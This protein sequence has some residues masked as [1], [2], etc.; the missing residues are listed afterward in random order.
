ME[1][2]SSTL[3]LY[4]SVIHPLL[5]ITVP[6]LFLLFTAPLLEGMTPLPA[7]GRWMYLL[8]LLVGVSETALGNILKEERASWGARLRELII[9]LAV[10]FLIFSLVRKPPQGPFYF[11]FV[12]NLV[13]GYRLTLIAGMWL[14]TFAI[15]NNYRSWEQ[16]VY[17]RGDKEG[18]RLQQCL[19]ESIV[20]ITDIKTR[21]WNVKKIC[22]LLLFLSLI[23]LLFAYGTGNPPSP[24]H[25]GVLVL[26]LL[27]VYVHIAVVNQALEEF[28]LTIDGLRI[29]YLQKLRQLVF[30]AVMLGVVAF[31]S[32][33][34]AGNRALLP[35]SLIERFLEFLSSLFSE[36][37]V[38]I[39]LPRSMPA[40]QQYDRIVD[41]YNQFDINNVEMF[42]FLENLFRMI[43]HALFAAGI[44]LGVI[45]VFGPLFSQEFRDYLRRLAL[46][47]ALSSVGQRVGY[48]FKTVIAVFSSIIRN[49]FKLLDGLSGTKKEAEFKTGRKADSGRH[50]WLKRRELDRLSKQMEKIFS[51]ARRK[52]VPYYN[53]QTLEEYAVR[54][55]RDLPVSEEPLADITRI[56]EMARF[57]EMIVGFSRRKEFSAR[58]KYV[59]QDLA[60]V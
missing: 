21:M 4:K 34:V 51:A 58:V 13:I 15:H 42:L 19:R 10:F 54:L 52:G 27:A 7:A 23:I 38:N 26:L 3:L 14:L 33:F 5:S 22:I 20:F 9:T 48:F 47:E 17:L 40:Q 59:L 36:R 25:I 50:S 35:V 57:S 60:S 46:T 56:Y 28:R 44:A 12:P 16:F 41:Y 6:F 43:K 8:L 53:H 49:G 31:G 11:R 55:T 30:A 39:R 37:E 29:P 45:L 18:P 1:K 24:F 32:V 2:K